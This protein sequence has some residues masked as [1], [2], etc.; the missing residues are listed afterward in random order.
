MGVED[1]A[2]GRRTWCA[3][4]G[5]EAPLSLQLPRCLCPPLIHIK[6][7]GVGVLVLAVWPDNSNS[8]EPYGKM[9]VT[10]R[11]YTHTKIKAAS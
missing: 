6:L 1:G 11:I 8:S 9:E 4:T 7:D 2:L 3:R 5:W 10:N